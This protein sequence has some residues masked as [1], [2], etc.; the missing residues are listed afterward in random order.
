[1]PALLVGTWYGMNFRHMPEL[2]PPLAY[3]LA[4]AVTVAAT[5]LMWWYLKRKKLL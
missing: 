5:A 3:P 2:N 4:W 1:V